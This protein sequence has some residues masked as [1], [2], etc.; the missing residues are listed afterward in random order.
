MKKFIIQDKPRACTIFG[1]QSW[2]L[3]FTLS[4]CSIKA[5]LFIFN[6]SGLV[7]MLDRS[8]LIII[9]LKDTIKRQPH[10]MLS[11]SWHTD[12]VAETLN[13][14]PETSQIGNIVFVLI[15]CISAPSIFICNRFFFPFPFLSR[16][17]DSCEERLHRLWSLAEGRQLSFESGMERDKG[18][19]RWLPPSVFLPVSAPWADCPLFH[20]SISRDYA[21]KQWKI[22]STMF[23]HQRCLLSD[24]H[25]SFSDS[26]EY[27][28]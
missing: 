2:M 22:H 6:Q 16:S 7:Q 13:D 5:C 26:H 23:P 3:N 19:M 20:N 4:L 18:S 15:S 9:S 27:G 10:P 24:L 8:G 21:A 12:L 14:M 17:V 25:L 28:R 1:K 11:Y